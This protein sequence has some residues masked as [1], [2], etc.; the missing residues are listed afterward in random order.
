MARRKNRPEHAGSIKLDGASFSIS[1]LQGYE[2]EAAFLEAMN[3]KGH[4]HI[5][6][7]AEDRDAKLKEVYALGTQERTEVAEEVKT[8]KAA[9]KKG[10]RR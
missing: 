8:K 2:S 10:K 3:T 5:F 4:A 9:P 1:S 7:G 6:E